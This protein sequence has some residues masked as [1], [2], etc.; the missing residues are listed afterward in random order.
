[1]NKRS[2]S[3]LHP[4]LVINTETAIDRIGAIASRSAEAGHQNFP[5]QI[6]LVRRTA[7]QLCVAYSNCRG[8]DW[9]WHCAS[10]QN[11]QLYLGE[12]CLGCKLLTA[13]AHLQ[14]RSKIDQA[15]VV[16]DLADIT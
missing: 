10:G 16:E 5:K 15:P 9:C 1:M 2:I 12:I 3:S 6:Q 8:E 7:Q 4:D 14:H 11:G 13:D